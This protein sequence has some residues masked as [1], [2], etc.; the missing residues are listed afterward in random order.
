MHGYL[1]YLTVLVFALGPVALHL[2][3]MPSMIAWGL[4]GFHLLFTLSTRYPLGLFR[5]VPMTFH[6]WLE[7]AAGPAIA[8]AP[9]VFGFHAEGAARMYFLVMGAVVFAVWVMT[10]YADKRTVTPGT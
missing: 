8:A 1:D 10:D 7:L 6:G 2:S 4:A 9:W 5:I 3:P